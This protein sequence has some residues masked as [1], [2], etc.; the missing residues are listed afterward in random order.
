MRY[1]RY[2]LA[3]AYRV[4]LEK[5]IQ[6]QDAH[7]T[8]IP[9][10]KI[11]QVKPRRNALFREYTDVQ[12][13]LDVKS[14]LNDHHAQAG[15]YIV[16]T[17][18]DWDDY[19]VR[20]EFERAA[21]A[22]QAEIEQRDRQLCDMLFDLLEHDTNEQLSP[23]HVIPTVL[24]RLRDSA[25]VAGHH[26]QLALRLDGRMIFNDMYISYSDA[27]P[28]PVQRM[29]EGHEFESKPFTPE[30]GAQVFRFSAQLLRSKHKPVSVEILGNQTFFE[31]DQ[32]LRKAFGHDTWDHMGG[33]WLLIPR[34]NR[35][36]REVE[37]GTCAPDP[38]YKLDGSAVDVAVAGVGLAVG[39][40][41]KYVYDFGN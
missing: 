35:R 31:L 24:A 27:G 17:I 5:R 38:N 11:V 23:Y 16:F 33:F 8:L 40:R 30:L 34:A 39:S 37:I 6:L 10:R 9:T 25:G 7:G 1:L 29:V 4:P 32:A 18:E 19:V 28:S 14:W 12:E 41:M 26:W 3:V 36:F 15:D 22:P 20:L 13:L 2:Y 21:D